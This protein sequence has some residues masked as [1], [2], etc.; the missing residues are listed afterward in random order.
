MENGFFQ[1]VIQ[2]SISRGHNVVIGSGT[3]GSANML[4]IAEDGQTAEV[5]AESRD[6]SYGRTVLPGE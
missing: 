5:G 1:Q 2:E 6:D 4:V 3:F